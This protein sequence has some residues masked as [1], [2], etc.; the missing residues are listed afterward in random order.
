MIRNKH[1]AVAGGFVAGVAL[2][3]ISIAGITSVRAQETPV[4]QSDQGQQDREAPQPPGGGGFGGG[5]GGGGFGG[6]QGGGGQRGPGGPGGFG[7]PG[8]GMQGGGAPVMQVSGNNI[9]ILRGNSLLWYKM[10]EDSKL[11]LNSQTELPRPPQ[12]RGGGPGGDQGG[13]PPEPPSE[14]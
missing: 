7:G 8:M 10:T 3:Y 11:R 6:P 5:Q 13:P 4:S 12:P 9:F 14:K 2:T 1:F